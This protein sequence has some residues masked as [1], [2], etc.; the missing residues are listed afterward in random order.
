MAETNTE[1]HKKLK[2]PHTAGK[3]SSALVRNDLEKKKGTTVS[4]KELFVATRARNP[5]CSYKDSNEDTIS[6][7]CNKSKKGY[8]KWRNKGEPFS[9]ML[10]QI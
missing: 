7:I 6:K 5:E 9:K 8:K 10:L 3:I 4:L 2:N 1:N